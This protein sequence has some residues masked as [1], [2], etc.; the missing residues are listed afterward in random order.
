M[1]KLII[2]GGKKLKGS[3][4]VSGAKNSTVALIPAAI[5]A[6]S[7]VTLEGVPDIQDVHSLIEILEE[8]NVHADFNGSTLVIDPTEMVSIPMPSGKINSLRASYYFMGALL[9]KF[10]EGVV[11]LP[12]GCDLGPRPIDQHLKGF[13][14]LGAEVDN[15]MGAM[16]FKKTDDTLHASTIYFDVVSIGATIN[17]MLAATRAE[18]ITIIENAAREPEIIDVATLLN[19]MG[20]EI[21]GAGTDTLRIKGVEELH[22]VTHTVIPDRIEAGTYLSIAA[23]IGEDVLVENVIFEHIDGLVAKMHE[24]GVDLEIDEDSVRV[25]NNGQPLKPITISTQPYPGFAT[26][27]QQPVTPLLLLADGESTITDTIYPQ[28]V[29]HVAELNRMGAD[30]SVESN[31]IL[32]RGGSQLS[33]AEVEAS[34]L[35]AGACLVTA[36]LMAEG[37][38][39][40]TGVEN[41]LRGYSNIVDKLVALGA[42]IE[43]VETSE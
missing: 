2:N 29:G 3:V 43:M 38:T 20:A 32:I 12:G 36:G 34:D 8:M 39:T 9:A 22:G 19:K 24:M 16:H 4:S 31:I 17:V 25:R 41:I 5:L 6:N 21:R 30:I 26:D 15:Q 40:V 13:R 27:L 14:A 10:G 18:G 23:A 35:R 33:G 11:G 37:T 1:K 42:D 7:P 28:R